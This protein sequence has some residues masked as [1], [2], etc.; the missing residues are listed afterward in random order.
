[1]LF[2]LMLQIKVFLLA[3]ACFVVLA[4]ILHTVAVFVLK[5][6]KIFDENYKSRWLVIALSYIIT[7]LIT[8]L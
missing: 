1:M 4:Q 2:G 8:G 5:E 6:G 3:I 7:V